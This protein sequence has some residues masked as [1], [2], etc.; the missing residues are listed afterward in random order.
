MI[1]ARLLGSR[2]WHGLV[3]R[4]QPAGR[5]QGAARHSGRADRP[6]D[7]RHRP[8]GRGSA[9]EKRWPQAAFRAGQLR[10]PG[11]SQRERIAPCEFPAMGVESARHLNTTMPRSRLMRNLAWNLTTRSIE[12]RL[13][14]RRLLSATVAACRFVALGQSGR[15]PRSHATP[16]PGRVGRRRQEASPVG[17]PVASPVAIGTGVRI[18]ICSRSSSFRPRSISRSGPP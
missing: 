9:V 2:R 5:G 13:G 4:R 14:R 10:P 6:V 12:R 8:S 1:A 16:E 11:L 18:D 7:G 15:R 3:W 17:S